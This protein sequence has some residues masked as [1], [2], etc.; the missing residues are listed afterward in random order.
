MGAKE[1]ASALRKNTSLT[2]LHLCDNQIGGK[3]AE[4]IAKALKGNRVLQRLHL[5]A[6]DINPQGIRALAKA[7]KTGGVASAAGGVAGAGGAAGGGVTAMGGGSSVLCEL[8]LSWNRFGPEG[9]KYIGVM[10]KENATLKELSVAHN[11]MFDE[12][13]VALMDGVRQ[14]RTLEQLDIS[15]NRVRSKGMEVTAATLPHNTSLLAVNVEQSQPQQ[16]GVVFEVRRD[17]VN[18]EK[19]IA[20]VLRRNLVKHVQ[21]VKLSVMMAMHARVGGGSTMQGVFRGSRIGDVSVLRE[22]WEFC[23]GAKGD[24]SA[25]YQPYHPYSSVERGAHDFR[26]AR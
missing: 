14:N 24:G 22:V 13:I 3:G 15:H 4:L 21:S 6:N 20:A 2:L 25:G 26:T 17:Y 5:A 9:A 8:N 1:L 19:A 16:L 12:G 18:E 10:L 11:K 23:F 7:L